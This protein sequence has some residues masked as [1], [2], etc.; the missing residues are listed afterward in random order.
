VTAGLGAAA[1]GRAPD[2][3]DPDHAALDSMLNRDALAAV[4]TGVVIRAV[5]MVAAR[6]TRAAMMLHLGVM[7]PGAAMPVRAMLVMAAAAIVGMILH[8][9]MLLAARLRTDAALVKLDAAV[10]DRA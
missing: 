9:G 2:L 5:A 1:A 10:P 8:P 7:L 3:R 6:V 4:G